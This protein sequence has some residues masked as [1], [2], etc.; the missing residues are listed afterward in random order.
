M[1]D[2]TRLKIESYRVGR[3]RFISTEALIKFCERYFQTVAANPS[4]SEQQ[5]CDTTPASP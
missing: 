3:R 1:P 5:P 2:G 4:H